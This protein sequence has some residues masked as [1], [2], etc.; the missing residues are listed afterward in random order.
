MHPRSQ[1]SATADVE[2]GLKLIENRG[3]ETL[4][5]DVSDLR[6]HQDIEDV[7][8]TDGYLLSDEMKINLLMLGV[9][10]LNGVG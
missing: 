4:H 2:S 6:Y 8:L 1:N 3:G 5:E 10:M 9:L 7:D